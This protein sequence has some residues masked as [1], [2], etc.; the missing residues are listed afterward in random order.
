MIRTLL[1]SACILAA[2]TGA[3]RAEDAPLA[4]AHIH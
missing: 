3:A 2:A 4:D 1:A